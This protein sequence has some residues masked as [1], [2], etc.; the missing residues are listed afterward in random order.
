MKKTLYEKKNTYSEFKSFFLQSA[1]TDFSVT[2]VQT[3]AAYI[4]LVLA[5]LCL[6]T[7]SMVLVI[8]AVTQAIMVPFVSKVREV[9]ILTW[10]V[11]KKK[12][13]GGGGGVLK[14]S[15]VYSSKKF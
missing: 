15:I 7:I 14:I 10:G 1:M 2:T 8:T 5:K 3:H 12:G 9:Y 11:E 4:A 6:V 13:G